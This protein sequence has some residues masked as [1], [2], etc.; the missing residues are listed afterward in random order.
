MQFVIMNE[1]KNQ[2]Q[3]S[4]KCSL[5]ITTPYGNLKKLILNE[6]KYVLTKKPQI[7]LQFVAFSFVLNCT[8]Y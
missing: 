4:D 7:K 8:L 3:I 5:K 6:N 2:K 1:V